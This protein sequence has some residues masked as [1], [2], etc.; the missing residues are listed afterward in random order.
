MVGSLLQEPIN[1]VFDKAVFGNKVVMAD[2]L[3][4]DQSGNLPSNKPFTHR[5]GSA[6]SN[7][8]KQ[9]KLVSLFMF[10][11]PCTASVHSYTSSSSVQS[12]GRAQC[13]QNLRQLQVEAICCLLLLV[14]AQYWMCSR[15]RYTDVHPT[16]SALDMKVIRHAG[17]DC[18]VILLG[19]SSTPTDDLSLQ[20]NI[21]PITGFIIETC[22]RRNVALK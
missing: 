20:C 17:V 5:G 1:A 14:S 10:L 3:E 8:M 12:I 9:P 15:P 4:A 22:D 18:R 16:A 19:Q 7:L 6:I 13:T 2:I 11:P 21:L